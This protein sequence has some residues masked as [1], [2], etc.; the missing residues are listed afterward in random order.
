MLSCK[1][2]AE[3]L[4]SQWM[5]VARQLLGEDPAARDEKVA[6]FKQLIDRDPNMQKFKTEEL[7]LNEVLFSFGSF[8]SYKYSH[9]KSY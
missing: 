4:G 6:A 9:D 3:E 2:P 1:L 7:L 8:L 5:E